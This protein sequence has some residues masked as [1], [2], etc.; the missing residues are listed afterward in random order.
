MREQDLEQLKMRLGEIKSMGWVKNRRPGNVGGVGNTLE[1]LLNVEENNLRRCSHC[2]TASRS[3][4]PL[5][6]WRAFSCRGMAGRTSRQ[7]GVTQ[8]GREAFARQ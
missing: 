8:Q 6:L 5:A 3:R 1:D 7:A 2:F 4:G